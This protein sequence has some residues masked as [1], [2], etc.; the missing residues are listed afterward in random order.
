MSADCC[1]KKR[2]CAEPSKDSAAD[3]SK[4]ECDD[5]ILYGC[6]MVPACR[7]VLWFCQATEIPIKYVE[8]SLVKRQHLEPWFIAINPLHTVPCLREPDGFTLTESPAIIRY[9]CSKYEKFQYYPQEIR[10]RALVDQIMDWVPGNLQR[11]VQTLFC[12]TF[13]TS[14]GPQRA[15]VLS[16]LG[17]ALVFLDTKLEDSE[18]LTGDKLTV[19]D[20]TVAI[21]L[22]QLVY[23][24]IPECERE[25]DRHP[26]LKALIRKAGMCEVF[27]Q[28]HASLQRNA[29]KL[30]ELSMRG[31]ICRDRTNEASKEPACDDADNSASGACTEADTTSS[32]TATIAC[33]TQLI[34]KSVCNE[35]DQS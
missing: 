26:K 21:E 20:M 14:R 34:A 32:S 10:Q 5:C 33:L 6:S 3:T 25:M 9:L 27:R 2:K 18:F 35:N 23:V 17:R 30:C 19:A 7:L 15:E 8:V 24:G 22:A 29:A 12:S 1:N 31:P 4:K 11:H 28:L 16:K 13:V